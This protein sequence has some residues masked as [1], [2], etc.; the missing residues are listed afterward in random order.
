MFLAQRIQSTPVLTKGATYGGIL[1]DALAAPSACWDGTRYVQTVSLWNIANAK[2]YSAFFTSPNLATWTYVTSSL[3]SP[4][5]TDYIKG[6]GSIAWF[7]G[8]Y[9][10]AYGHYPSGSTIQ[11][12]IATSSDL[13]TWTTVHDPF[14]AGGIFDLGLVI[15]PASGKLEC[16]NTN[17]TDVFMSDSPDGSTW[18]SRGTML[19]HPYWTKDPDFGEAHC[20]YYNNNRHLTTDINSPSSAGASRV[21]GYFTAPGTSGTPTWTSTG[22]VLGPAP[23]NAWE[24]SQVF[25]GHI[26]GAFDRGDGRGRKL[27]MLYAGGDN[28]SPTDNTNSSIGLAYL[29]LPGSGSAAV[30][31]LLTQ[32][33]AL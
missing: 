24:S 32:M 8:L 20:T 12:A 6:N 3:Q 26:V 33:R 10:W 4:A 31:H 9:Y 22:S 17:A 29:D 7:G 23:L 16:W 28:N 11:S 18:T 13:V 27:W 25:D 1:A 21:R 19:T 2:W 14:L 5:G 15:N 30:K